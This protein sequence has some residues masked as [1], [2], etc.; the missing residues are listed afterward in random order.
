[1]DQASCV[2]E[3]VDCY[4]SLNT[5]VIHKTMS[6]QLM[7]HSKMGLCYGCGTLTQTVIGLMQPHREGLNV[8]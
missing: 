8:G 4:K 1:M 2:K 5:E 3:Y 7:S 6:D